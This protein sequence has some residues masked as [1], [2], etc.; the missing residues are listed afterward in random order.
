[1]NEKLKKQNNAESEWDKIYA[2][3]IPYSIYEIRE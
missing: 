3:S 1:M 2:K